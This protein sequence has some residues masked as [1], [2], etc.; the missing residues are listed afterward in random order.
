[1]ENIKKAGKRYTR[2]ELLASGWTNSLIDRFLTPYGKGKYAYFRAS[3]VA[4]VEQS[5][6]FQTAFQEYRAF[7]TQRRRI[8]DAPEEERKRAAIYFASQLTQQLHEQILNE[9]EQ[10]LVNIW[11]SAFIRHMCDKTEISH[12]TP[13][14]LY[15]D[16]CNKNMEHYRRRFFRTADRSWIMFRHPL[17]EPF[18][19]EYVQL[20]CRIAHDE[21]KNLKD[22]D[23]NVPLTSFFRIPGFT[24]QYPEKESLYFC[25]LMGFASSKLPE[26]L[27]QILST[28]SCKKDWGTIT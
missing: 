26:E 14:Q 23:I 2:K 6:E 20:L 27:V 25:Y 22:H 17:A 8:E 24:E 15:D 12:K 1:M 21:L 5:S 19:K 4:E 10:I 13:Q 11:H 18:A 28:P 7:V 16:L 9:D 3:E